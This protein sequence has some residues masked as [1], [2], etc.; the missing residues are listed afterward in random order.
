MKFGRL[1]I[2]HAERGQRGHNTEIECAQCA[3]CSF[4]G[5]LYVPMSNDKRKIPISEI[6]NLRSM[7]VKQKPA[8]ANQENC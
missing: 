5:F 2:I 3:H 8:L 7:F 6:E 4:Y 1:D